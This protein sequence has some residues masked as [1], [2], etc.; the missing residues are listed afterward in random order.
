MKKGVII[1]IVVA[2]VVRG[3]VMWVKS[4]YNGRVTK[5]ESVESAW[6]QVENV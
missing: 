5:Q 2:V 3:I 1:L 6:S 4:T